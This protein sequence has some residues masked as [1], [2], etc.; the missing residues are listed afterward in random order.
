MTSTLTRTPSAAAEP[1]RRRPPDACARSIRVGLVTADPLSRAGIASLIVQR[2]EM[3][4]L[5]DSRRHESNL[6]V[7]VDRAID[8]VLLG[9]LTSY[10]R[11]GQL[12]VC[13]VLEEPGDPGLLATAAQAGLY[14]VIW[15]DDATVAVVAKVLRRAH[16]DVR[17]GTS[18][19]DRLAALEADLAR[20]ESAAPDSGVPDLS[21]LGKREIMVLR[22]IADGLGTADIAPLIG[23]SERTV[24]GILSTVIQRHHLRNRTHAVTAALRQGLI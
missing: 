1:E 6:L 9:A 18:V 12:P 3:H 23:Y 15:R 17:G 21:G 8:L 4:L 14:G 2:S 10:S 7:V 20:P 13:A 5:P 16:A 24:K 22:L 19:A 11:G